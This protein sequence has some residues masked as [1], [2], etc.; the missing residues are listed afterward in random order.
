MR[1]HHLNCGLMA[2]LG[3]ALYGT[4][5]YGG[6][7][8]YGTAFGITGSQAHAKVHDFCAQADCADGAVP[9]SGLTAGRDGGLYGT[10][11]AGGANRAGILFRLG[12]GTR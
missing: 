7:A 2:P 12:S 9:A 6:A 3:G 8:G 1:V 5:A 4:T 11:A 10:T